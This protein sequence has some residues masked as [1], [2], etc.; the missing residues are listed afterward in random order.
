MTAAEDSST[1]PVAATPVE[2]MS[3]AKRQ[4]LE[5]VAWTSVA[6]DDIAVSGPPSESEGFLQ[7]KPK[8]SGKSV[9]IDLTPGK[10]WLGVPF[11]LD[12]AYTAKKSEK[13]PAFL[14]GADSTSAEG[15][16]LVLDIS[17]DAQKG[18]LL[19]LEEGLKA[20]AEATFPGQTWMP[21]VKNGTYLSLKAKIILNNSNGRT[22]VKV[23]HTDKTIENGLGYDFLKPILA[24][25]NNLRGLECKAVVEICKLWSFKG[26]CGVV[27]EIRKLVLNT[28]VVKLETLFAG[29]DDEDAELLASLEI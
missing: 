18:F 11:G 13:V 12:M 2:A 21:S 10:A 20:L 3:A 22:N 7:T 29:G 6:V 14:G 16:P 4:C 19:K 28:N 8:I 1:T 25:Y 26:Q 23:I 9:V 15:V 5:V 17:D 24:R 27:Y